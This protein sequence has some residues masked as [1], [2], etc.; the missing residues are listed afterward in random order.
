MLNS[1]ASARCTSHTLAARRHVLK[2]ESYYYQGA[3]C[4]ISNLT[5][6]DP[7]QFTRRMKHHMEA[8]E[9]H[10]K[11]VP[12]SGHVFHYEYFWLMLIHSRRRGV[13]VVPIPFPQTALQIGQ[14]LEK[15]LPIESANTCFPDSFLIYIYF[16]IVHIQNDSTS[17]GW[18]SVSTVALI[19]PRVYV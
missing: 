13:V 5:L 17:E 18:S 1:L 6:N 15:L 9:S 14:A 12:L 8:L 19:N 2:L 3:K 16:L 4:W 10:S 7:S 11:I